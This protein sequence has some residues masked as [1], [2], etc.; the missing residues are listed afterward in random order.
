MSESFLKP[1]SFFWM[2]SHFEALSH[3][4]VHITYLIFCCEAVNRLCLPQAFW[5]EKGFSGEIVAGSSTNCPFSAT[6]DATSSNGNA[7]LV[8]F[9]AGEQ[10]TQWGS[11]EVM[12][13]QRVDGFSDIVFIFKVFNLI[14]SQHWLFLSH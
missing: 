5:K 8:G 4:F 11:K 10:A 6:F 3:M 9:I 12:T 13:Y 7:A 14:N 1:L 2:N